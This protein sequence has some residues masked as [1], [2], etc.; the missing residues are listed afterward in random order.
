M[1]LITIDLHAHSPYAGASGKSDFQR[2]VF[3]MKHKGIDVYGSGDILLEKWERELDSAFD[4]NEKKQFWTLPDGLFL[5]P[6]T[7]VIVTVPYPYNEK[8]RKLFHMVILFADRN[9]VTICRKRFFD[10][11]SKLTIGRP[12]ITFD[13]IS[14]FREFFISLN[15]LLEGRIAFIPAHVMTPEGILGGKNPVDSIPEIFGEAIKIITALETGLSAD[16]EMLAGISSSL[17]APLVSFSDSHSAAFNKLGRE[18][19]QI[20]VDTLS[21]SGIIESLKNHSIIKTAE[22]PPFEG[23]YYLTGHRGDRPG[24]NGRDYICEK[25]PR[26][27]LCPVCGKAFIPGVKERIGKIGGTSAVIQDFIYQIPL[28]E[29]IAEVLGTG[30][31]SQKAMKLYI[32]IVSYIGKESSLWLTDAETELSGRV[33]DEIIHA[34]RKIKHNK[35]SV[36]YGFDGKYG[37]ITGLN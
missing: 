21:S 13:N 27:E 30:V 34:V 6:Q 18:F 10:E 32:D 9:A 3:V 4:F 22:F 1:S 17:G 11:G 37:K 31:T 12:F 28:I 7:E 35:M 5:M 36:I 16:P 20:A 8:A 15:T 19:T 23:R 33:P 26:P 25:S 24:H 2:L 29:I 14:R